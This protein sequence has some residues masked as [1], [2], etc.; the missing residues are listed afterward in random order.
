MS[1][2][3]H[4]PEVLPIWSL[5]SLSAQDNLSETSMEG[6]VPSQEPALDHQP[7]SSW[8]PQ[9]PGGLSVG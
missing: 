3:F 7:S 4:L 2:F 1:S 9:A 8:D 6:N 5:H